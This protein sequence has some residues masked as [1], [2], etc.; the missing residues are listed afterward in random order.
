MKAFFY[1][2]TGQTYFLNKTLENESEYEITLLQES[3]LINLELIINAGIDITQYNY[4]HI[5]DLSR[6]YFINSFSIIRSSLFK[7]STSIDVLMTYKDIILN[8]QATIVKGDSYNPYHSSIAMLDKYQNKKIEW[9]K[10]PYS[11]DAS[12]ILIATSGEKT[13][14]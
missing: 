10:T 11:D 1:K 6:Y 7:L 4:L 3:N 14:E 5:P 2:Y 8:S 9:T 13:N 12:Y